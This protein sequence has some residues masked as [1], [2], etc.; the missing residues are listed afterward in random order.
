M[1][2]TLTHKVN[3]EKTIFDNKNNLKGS[4]EHSKGSQKTLGHSEDTWALGCT[5]TLR[6]LGDLDFF[7]FCSFYFTL[8]LQQ[9]HMNNAVV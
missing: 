3:Y 7:F 8:A 6:A 1:K 2:N 5:S 4:F 9:L